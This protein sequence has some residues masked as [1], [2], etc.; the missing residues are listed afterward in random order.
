MTEMKT[1][2]QP[3]MTVVKIQPGKFMMQSNLVNAVESDDTDI[4]FD[5]SIT[6]GDARV[7][8]YDFNIWDDEW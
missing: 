2:I 3:T 5:T 7:K 8:V 4:L 1:Y 6:T